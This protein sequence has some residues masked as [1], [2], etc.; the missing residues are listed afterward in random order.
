VTK[1]KIFINKSLKIHGDRYNY[2]LVNYINNRTKIKIICKE[3]GIFEQIP[4]KHLSG[5]G[6]QICGGSKV[7]TTE[8]FIKE[9]KKIHNDK[10]DYSLLKYINAKTKVKIICSIHGEFKQTPDNHI[11]EKCG[12]PKCA[13]RYNEHIFIEKSNKIHNN[14]YDYSLVKYEGSTVKIK[15]ICPKHGEFEQRPTQHILGQG[16]PKCKY[17]K[18]CDNKKSFIEKSNKI[19]NNIYDYSLVN[20]INSYTKV[21]IIC[22]KHGIFKQNPKDHINSKQGCPYCKSSKGEKQIMLFLENNN[23]NFKYQKTFEYCIN[24]L[25]LYFDFYLPEYN[26]CIEYNGKQHYEPIDY[27]GG[28]KTLKYIQNLIKQTYCNNN[29]INYII[30]RYDDNLIEKMNNII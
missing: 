5:R 28:E 11:N 24:K 1:T 6:C 8:E 19:H 18:F 4:A 16:C 10:Y 22:K 25:P 17:E 26:L 13:N 12:C 3:H 30:I 23:I 21:K 29:Y 9:S 7:K 27:F 14:I 20:Y 15:I 2:C